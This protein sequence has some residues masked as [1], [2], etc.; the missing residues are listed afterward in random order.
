MSRLGQEVGPFAFYSEIYKTIRVADE[1]W[2]GL[3]G[4]FAFYVC[5]ER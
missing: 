3:E 2:S 1:S 5:G 4:R